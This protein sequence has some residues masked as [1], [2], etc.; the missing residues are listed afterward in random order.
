MAKKSNVISGIFAV[1][2]LVSLTVGIVS[3]VPVTQNITYQGKLTDAA[4]N[5]LTGTYSVTFK[6][7]GVSTGGTALAADTHTVQA[8]KGLFT[9]QITADPGFF[10]GRALWL[11]V[12][13]GAD[14]E[15]TPRQELRPV[16]YALSLR[17]GAWITSEVLGQGIDPTNAINLQSRGGGIA[18]NISTTGAGC[19]G[20]FATTRDLGSN[21]IYGISEADGTAAVAGV[22]NGGNSYSLYGKT[23]KSGSKGVYGESVQDVGVYGKGKDG[24]YFTTNQAGTPSGDRRSGVNVSTA[25]D[26]N[27]GIRIRTTG[28]TSNGMNVVTEGDSSFGLS[29]F[30]EGETSPG[31]YTSTSGRQSRGVWVTTTN[32]SSDGVYAQTSGSY[33]RGVYAY[34][35]QN[36][37]I[38][39]DTG[40]P[41][42]YG[43]Y[44]PD[45]MSAKAYDANS[46]DVAEYM[47]VT[48]KVTSGTVLIIWD[49]GKLHPA[50]T[51]N[52][53]RVAGIV[54]TAPGVTLGT[55]ENGNP[56]EQI[57]AVAG[58]V[59]CKVDANYG[60]IHAGDLLTTS[61]N[62]GYA[63][64]AIDPKIGTI[65]GKAMGS[66]ESGTG[67]I[68]VLVT[69]Q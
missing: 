40:N 9:T 15:M 20:V 46:G 50:T 4:G 53:T 17:P 31:L 22:A 1:V 41:N 47:Q 52:D 35:A 28:Y 34:S 5:P 59:P 16:P 49:D 38:Y 51:A 57:I 33:S 24:G 61:D 39:A 63:M 23:T 42:Y 6:L 68:E 27:Q 66:L 7:Y 21:A 13:V 10:D 62:P 67:T 64:K 44:T 45:K 36:N 26:Y 19:P 32:E 3:A 12:T 65:L 11:G 55:K 54:S 29:A 43:V 69:L 56:G 25:F 60:S 14:P 58:R 18:L 2:V 37:A 48:E 30:T 8:S